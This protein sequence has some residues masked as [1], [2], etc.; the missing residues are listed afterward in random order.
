MPDFRQ[1]EAGVQTAI[2]QKLGDALGFPAIALATL[3]CF[4]LRRIHP[5]SS[6]N[7]CE[8]VR[9]VLRATTPVVPSPGNPQATMMPL[10]TSIP[11]KRLYI[12]S[13]TDI[14][15][16]CRWG[17]RTLPASRQEPQSLVQKYL[18]AT[19]QHGLQA[20]DRSPP[21][22]PPW[23]LQHRANRVRFHP[24]WWRSV[25]LSFV[26]HKSRNIIYSFKFCHLTQ[27]R[28]P[29]VRPPMLV[30]NRE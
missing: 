4:R 24:L 16:S 9:Y 12:V 18:P 25:A 27:I 19:F 11:Q 26:I 29:A 22:S 17:R 7:R 6:R 15:S 3:Q 21:I 2:L 23:Y 14:L 20:P 8:K 13:D 28:G 30:S 1:H 10:W 5:S